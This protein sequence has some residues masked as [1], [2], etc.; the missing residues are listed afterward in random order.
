MMREA[1]KPF[2]FSWL[3]GNGRV[4]LDNHFFSAP[5]PR[6]RGT[7]KFK[8]LPKHLGCATVDGKRHIVFNAYYLQPSVCK[9]AIALKETGRYYL[10]FVGCCIRD[11]QKPERFFDQ[12]Y[13][14]DDYHELYRLLA[15]SSPYAI[16]A[17]MQPLV[18]G[19]IAVE[20][21]KNNGVRSIIDINDSLY[22]MRKDPLCPECLV[23]RDILANATCFVH[24]MPDE[25]VQEI[26]EAWR[27]STPGFLVH[28]LP[29]ESLF[30]TCKRLEN[31][32]A[33]S[34]VFA[35]G[36]M[37]Y[38]IAASQGHGNHVM[39]PLIQGLCSMGLELT[40]FVNQNA[41]DMFWDEHDHYMDFQDNFPNFHFKKGVPFFQLPARLSNHHFA[42]YYENVHHSDYHEHHF[43][44]NMA[45]KLFSYVEAGL[46]VIIHSQA[47]YM[48]DFVERHGMGL[49]YDIDNLKGISDLVNSC[50]HSLLCRNVEAFRKNQN[51]S[52]NASILEQVLSN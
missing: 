9:K 18:N 37:P 43:N 25:A 35:G 20:A 11:E 28:S 5:M 48:K 40:F 32:E 38:R 49:V 42:I 2:G 39:D 26:R 46:P 8:A 3:D 33:P 6:G 24:K 23:E 29:V 17:F 21:S 34:L 16:F 41:R 22:Y 30:T 36:I 44:I 50:D 15:Y 31:G 7:L 52:S 19:A 10:T 12:C 14:V 1:E 47:R 45:T 27:I 51:N 4:L 13:E